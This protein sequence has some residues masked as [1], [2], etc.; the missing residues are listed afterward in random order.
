M[1]T[2]SPILPTATLAACLLAMA[3]PAH[4]LEPEDVVVLFNTKSGDSLRI[5][6]Y[7]L[8]AR[9]IPRGNLVPIVCD[10]GEEVTEE[11]YRTSIVPQLRKQLADRKLS[12][13]C[14]VTTYDLPLRI[15][16][17]SPPPG[18]QQEA[19]GYQKQLEETLNALEAQ[20]AAYDAIAPAPHPAAANSTAPAP[21]TS[22]PAAKPAT[23]QPRTLASVAGTLN[24]TAAAA[25]HR[26]DALSPA[27]RSEALAQFITAHEK[28]AGLIGILSVLRVPDDAP[29]ADPGRRRLAEY[30]T[31]L[32][33]LETRAQDALKRL[34][35]PQGRR[36]L[37]DLRTKAGGLVARARTLEEIL[38]YLKPDQTGACFDNELALALWDH[39]YPRGNWVLNPQNLETYLA[40][41]NT[42]AEFL[43]KP[44]LV[45]RLDGL[46]PVA[47]ENMILTGLKTETAGLEGK[48]YLDARGL[49][50][51]DA[52]AAYDADIRKAAEWM[53]AHTTMETVLDDRPELLAARDAPD[54][55]L[56]CGWYS[57]HS[58]QE[59]CQWVKGAVGYHV[60]SYEMT[61]LHDPKETGWVT[62][63]LSRGF[64]GTLGATAEPYLT[65]FPK[66]SLFFPLL[67]SGEFTQ[68]EVWQVTAPMLSWR[69]A[70]VGDP[71]YNPFKAKPRVKKE[72]LLA[73]PILRNAF[74]I[75]RTPAIPSPATRPVTP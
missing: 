64:C 13:K 31:Q 63:L 54:A 20:A 24:T 26:I 12:P 23:P 41:Q 14:L 67:V 62:N 38:A 17:R 47:V 68:G 73:H 10:V 49:H 70:Y 59:T 48:L 30:N 61:T 52:Y 75:L 4:A 6:R 39:A 57:V 71:L 16:D 19:A 5:A 32:A 53:K 69:T 45:A 40:I 37:L 29:N 15:G 65:S 42:P 33:G 22:L 56:Y 34:G 7:Y 74:T 18:D 66:P 21:P 50:G 44:I 1:P 60:A 9:R 43:P 35:T 2:R 72:D 51:T 46:S 36:D 55:A 27:A 25:A 3:P 11:F 28:T 58:Y 8:A